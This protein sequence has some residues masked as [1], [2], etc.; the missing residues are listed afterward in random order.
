MLKINNNYEILQDN[1]HKLLSYAWQVLTGKATPLPVNTPKQIMQLLAEKNYSEV[2]KALNQD[3]DHALGIVWYIQDDL[4]NGT[5]AL[6]R[7]ARQQTHDK[8]KL[9][10]DAPQKYMMQLVNKS[11]GA[12]DLINL[13]DIT[14]F[15]KEIQIQKI[16]SVLEEALKYLENLGILNIIEYNTQILE[17]LINLGIKDAPEILQFA[18]EI[19]NFKDVHYHV[20]TLSRVRK[21][22]AN[23]DVVEAEV[24]LNGYTAEQIVQYNKIATYDSKSNNNVGVEWFDLTK[25]SLQKQLIYQHLNY[26]REGNRVTPTQLIYS[27]INIRNAYMKVTAIEDLGVLKVIAENIH[28]GTPSTAMTFLPKKIQSEVTLN[29]IKQLKTYISEN[30]DINL[31]SLNSMTP[32]DI[33]GENF[34]I[35]QVREVR[36]MSI[37][38]FTLSVSPINKWRL[39]GGGRNQRSFRNILNIIYHI[40]KAHDFYKTKTKNIAK[41]LHNTD[42]PI[43]YKFMEILSLGRYKSIKTRALEE[44]ELL[45]SSANKE[46]YLLS[47][48]LRIAVSAKEILEDIIPSWENKDLALV[49]KIYLLEN[50][51]KLPNGCL[52]NLLSQMTS[53]RPIVNVTFCKSG[54]DRTGYMMFINTVSAVNE[55]LDID[56]DSVEAKNNREVLAHSGHAQ[57]MA[58]IQ[59]GTI[60]CH[61]LKMMSE[62][63]LDKLDQELRPVL[64]QASSQLNN[65]INVLKN[66]KNKFKAI[67]DFLL[68][69]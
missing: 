15:E 52:N 12:I 66:S 60:G 32:Y 4:G 57:E 6:V 54:K 11:R 51:I 21:G 40:I 37:L 41:Y 46:Q 17:I 68:N 36:N 34:T 8:M 67:K 47:K 56:K 9:E 63:H 18:R 33:R 45:R 59:G 16:H 55:Y 13:T 43:F 69:I 14:S 38:P 20:V 7:D 50:S 27:F 24:M 10:R 28:S 22:K 65:K 42:Y 2:I 23:Y 62:F 49:N 39:I 61:S 58:G 5:G 48:I 25:S 3:K 30:C 31:S 19:S 35:D 26:I 1:K 44:V 64:A 29:N 53:I